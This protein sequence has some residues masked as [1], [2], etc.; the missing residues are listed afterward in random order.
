MNELT[1]ILSYLETT[2]ARLLAHVQEPHL[3]RAPAAGGWSSGQVL[4]H[5]IRTEQYFYPLF[6][7]L[8]KLARLPWL[9]RGLDRLNSALC[10][11]LGMKFESLGDQP[12]G[13]LR[14][15]N[16]QFKGRFAAP[17]FLQPG[18]RRYDLSALLARRARTRARTLAALRRAGLAGLQAV[19]FSHPILGTFTVLEFARFLGKHEEWHTEQLKRIARQVAE[20][21]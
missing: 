4:A 15:F 5:L 12:S 3:N 13:D 6:F 9:V 16:P 18:Q 1:E 10:L 8:P 11:A 7:L 14:Q 21:G 19:R 17:A 20:A 2:Q